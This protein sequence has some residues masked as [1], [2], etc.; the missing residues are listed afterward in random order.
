[1]LARLTNAFK[2]LVRPDD[3]EKV[4][5]LGIPQNYGSWGLVDASRP[6]PTKPYFALQNWDFFRMVSPYDFAQLR[7]AARKLFHNLG[8]ARSAILQRTNYSFGRAW[9]PRFE[10]KDKV[11]GTLATTLLKEEWY[12]VADTRGFDFVTSLH[13]ASI[14]MDRDGDILI[15]LSETED[16]YPQIQTVLAHRIMVGDVYQTRIEKGPYRGLR[17]WNGVILNDVDRPVAYRIQI[18][19]DTGLDDSDY[20][21]ISARDAILVSD[22]DVPDQVR[23]LPGLTHAIQD[24]LDLKSTVGFEKQAAMLASS[25][26]LIEENEQGGPTNMLSLMQQAQA[27]S[28]P[29][30]V[31]P[32]IT[33]QQFAGGL[34]KYFRSGTGGKMQVL[35]NRNPSENWE[36]FM[37]RLERQAC[38]GLPWPFELALDASALS[39]TNSRLVI[40]QAMRAIQDRQE[41]FRP[42][43]KRIIGYAVAKLIKMG[44]LPES[45]EWFRWDFTLPPRLSVDYGRD[46]MAD[47]AD[48]RAGIQNLC[49]IL[50]AEG[51]DLEEHLIRRAREV[52]LRKIIAKK[53]GTEFGVE[54]ADD[55][56]ALILPNG[57]PPGSSEE[58]E[59]P[60]SSPNGS[61]APKPSLKPV[62]PTVSA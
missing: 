55:E 19:G 61:R 13:L 57:Q 17:I 9:Q 12:G 11:W 1:M 10:G 15:L 3:P 62:A 20:T 7:S 26:G 4:M 25:I 32:G 59:P 43:A 2:E 41:L 51:K 53:V 48:W 30:V 50:D 23:G 34:V 5:K 18:G 24:L 36:R 16:G 35:Q 47:Q 49:D 28:P 56:M 45:P 29:I 21:D 58:E 40:G 38:V 60:S 22:P 33:M 14:C 6:D 54:I 46:K 44:R 52:A 27:G 31:P 37:Q 42:I 8:S 39:G